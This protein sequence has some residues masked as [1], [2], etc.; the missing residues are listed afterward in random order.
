MFYG[1]F[2]DKDKLVSF[3]LALETIKETFFSI[4]A[5][6]N[7]IAIE[8]SVGFFKDKRFKECFEKYALTTQEK[9]LGW[10]IHTLLWA[11]RH[12]LEISGDFVECGVLKGFSSAVI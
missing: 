2:S 10:R 4:Y 9:S 1:D 8:K 5:A 7:L 3:R 6:D 11:T 12:C